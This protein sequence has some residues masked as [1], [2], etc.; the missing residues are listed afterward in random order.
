M[1]RT[2]S[3][4]ITAATLAAIVMLGAWMPTLTVPTEAQFAATSGAVELA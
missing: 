4:R 1:T 3:S 2:F